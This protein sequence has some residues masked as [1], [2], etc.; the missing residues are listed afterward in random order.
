MG[1][2][3]LCSSTTLGPTPHPPVLLFSLF[4]D[5]ELSPLCPDSVPALFPFLPGTTQRRVGSSTTESINSQSVEPIQARPVCP[6]RRVLRFFRRETASESNTSICVSAGCHSYAPSLAPSELHYIQLLFVTP[7]IVII[8]HFCP[9]RDWK[10]NSPGACFQ[11]CSGRSSR[12]RPSSLS[13]T[14]PARPVA[15]Y[16]SL[17][18]T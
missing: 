6:A 7:A 4:L 14:R 17:S 16:R 13:L 3:P 2:G 9:G 10:G 18:C 11:N 15:Y 1:E 5:R 8:P 12:G